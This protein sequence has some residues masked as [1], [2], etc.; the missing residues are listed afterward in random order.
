MART[1]ITHITDDID[2]SK[3]AEEV[4]FSFRGTD[5]VI[6]LSKKN[7]AA[8]EKALKPFLE[9]A[10]KTGR[11]PSGSSSRKPGAT[12]SRKSR[13]PS[14]EDFAAIR[15]WAKANGVEV[16]ERGRVARAVI[17]QYKAATS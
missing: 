2:G 13:A 10:T 11:K 15:D 8:M 4:T 6:D 5:Y 3:D 16:S 14:G 1:T 12:P 7:Q 17:E 9:A